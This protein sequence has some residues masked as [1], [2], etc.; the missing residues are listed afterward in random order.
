M[1]KRVPVLLTKECTICFDDRTVG[2]LNNVLLPHRYKIHTHML[3]DNLI[4]TLQ[5]TDV[6]ERLYL[7]FNCNNIF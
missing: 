7:P 6:F 1:A 4:L 3:A 2:L 5:L